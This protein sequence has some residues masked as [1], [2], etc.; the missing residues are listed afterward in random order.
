MNYIELPL[1]I[2]CTPP[3]VPDV[4]VIES[5]VNDVKPVG[6]AGE[7][8][9]MI[10]PIKPLPIVDQVPL[11]EFAM[12]GPCINAPGALPPIHPGADPLN[13]VGLYMDIAEAPFMVPLPSV[14]DE[15][16]MVDGVPACEAGPIDIRSLCI[17]SGNIPFIAPT[18]PPPIP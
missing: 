3:C 17:S 2:P 11:A 5:V 9:P 13:P 15:A 6:P 4:C 10:D 8:I 14:D 7:A 1:P 12:R 16:V 18:V